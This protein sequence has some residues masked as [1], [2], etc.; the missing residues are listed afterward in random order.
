MQGRGGIGPPWNLKMLS[1]DEIKRIG[2]QTLAG[3]KVLVEAMAEG[4]EAARKE[5]LRISEELPAFA[6]DLMNRKLN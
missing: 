2:S 4:S 5:V 3:Y 1:D 6:K